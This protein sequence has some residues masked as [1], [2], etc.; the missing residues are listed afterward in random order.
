[1]SPVS[2][3]TILR[4]L[5]YPN[6][7]QYCWDYPSIVCW[8]GTNS[9]R[10]FFVDRKVRSDSAKKLWAMLCKTFYIR[11]GYLGAKCQGNQSRVKLFKLPRKCCQNVI[12]P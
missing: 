8:D 7:A 3:E 9:L 2:V 4:L 5:D 11:Y 10:G 1:M 12:I 6:T